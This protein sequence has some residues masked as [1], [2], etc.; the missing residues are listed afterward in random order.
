MW[1]FLDSHDRALMMRLQ[2]LPNPH[3][4]QRSA[5]LFSL[6]GDGAGYLV[7]ALLMAS[8]DGVS[9]RQFLW[10]GLASFAIELPLYWL[11]KNGLKRNRPCHAVLGIAAIVQPHDKFSLPSGHSAAAFVFATLLTWYWPPLAPIVY[12][13]AGLVGCSRVILGVHYLG[14]VVA[15]AAL[16]YWAAKLGIYWLN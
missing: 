13:W 3:Y 15:G 6:S 12:L 4:W 10:S 5:R 8:F 14:D 11:L 2:T 7:F 16:G 1:H 9:G